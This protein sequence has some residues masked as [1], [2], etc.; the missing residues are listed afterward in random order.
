MG[1]PWRQM[2]AAALAGSALTAMATDRLR[3]RKHVAQSFAL[4]WL[5][6]VV[7]WA[8]WSTF[9]YPHLLSPLRHLPTPAGA[10]W[11]LGHS[12]K[13]VGESPGAPLREWITG[14]EHDGLIRYLFA[15]NRERL[16]VSSPKAL[17]E[18][19]VSKN[20][21]FEKPIAVRNA[22]GRVLGNGI[23]LAEGDEHKVQRRNLLPAFHYRHIKDLP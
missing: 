12:R 2:A 10:H 20:Y 16:L 21:M 14:M 11:L 19:L 7:V 8:V 18:V 17:A 23:L 3:S 9:V 13:L 15:F 1:L 6:Q 5:V 22:L 4:L